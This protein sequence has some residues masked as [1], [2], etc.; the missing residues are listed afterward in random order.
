MERT[1]L[2]KLAI[3]FAN[4]FLQTRIG[5]TY[6]QFRTEDRIDMSVPEFDDLMYQAVAIQKEAKKDA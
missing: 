5:H 4:D 6:H 1:E 3:K 2:E